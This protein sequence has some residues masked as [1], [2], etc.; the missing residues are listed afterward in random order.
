MSRTPKRRRAA[1]HIALLT[2]LL[3]ALVGKVERLGGWDETY[4]LTQLSSLVED[5][6]LDLRNDAL[7][8]TLPPTELRRLLASTLPSGA[9]ANTF[10]IGPA[11]M[12]APAYLAGLPARWASGETAAR[13]SRAQ[14]AALHLLALAFAFWTLWWLRS[15]LCRAGLAR[16]PA[17]LATAALAL[18]TPFLIYAFRHYAG[19]HLVSV[20]AACAFVAAVVR[21]ERRRDF[22]S[23]LACGILLGL[24]FLVRWQDLVMAAALLVPA[25][26]LLRASRAGAGVS[27]GRALALG[28]A[29]AAGFAVIAGLQFHAW[30]IERAQLFAMPQG[31]G[32]LNL[33]RPELVRFL[34][35]GLSGLLPWSPLVLLCL[36]GLLLPWRLRLPR[37]WAAVA[38]LVLAAEIYLNACVTDWWGGASY[39]ARRMTSTLPFLALGLANLARQ[40][41][42]KSAWASRVLPALLVVVCLWGTVTAQLY[43][44]GVQDLGPVFLGRPSAGTD[45]TQA[46]LLDPDSARRS[47]RFPLSLRVPNYLE[48]S[49]LLG[50]LLAL[51]AM[52]ALLA[53]ALTAASGRPRRRPERADSA[54]AG[55]GLAAAAL[56][57][58]ALATAFHLRLATGPPPDTVE[59]ASWRKFAG[60]AVGP[61]P[62]HTL[63]DREMRRLE[64]P[65]AAVFDTAGP[66]DA[67]RYLHLWSLWQR[68]RAGKAHTVL[69]TL[70]ARGYPAAAELIE[71]GQAAGPGGTIRF[72]LPGVL[73]GRADSE[74][75]L[76]LRG[77]RALFARRVV[78]TAEL[79]APPEASGPLAAIVAGPT[80]MVRLDL[81][82]GSSV[83]STPAVELTVPAGWSGQHDL[84]LTWDGLEERAL[85]EI[86]S[87]SRYGL[88]L[89]APGAAPASYSDDELAVAFAP[90]RTGGSAAGSGVVVANVFVA[91]APRRWPVPGESV[92][93][94]AVTGGAGMARD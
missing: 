26:R 28:G 17:L 31:P 58:L 56:A 87:R 52:A 32:Y 67:Y 8:A 30:G 9:L 51:A 43:R 57:V 34:F 54:P 46:G 50:R 92:P 27:V 16:G 6:D 53:L 36:I 62:D 78:V 90:Q 45:S 94:G 65:A 48:S 55:R 93:A 75:R 60:A 84:R 10:S 5:G 44:S 12:L 71:L 40:R 63:L 73:L 91:S 23:A 18:G 79:T 13:W 59:R 21:F 68:H 14:L 64:Q 83:L 80:T 49:P 24:V 29:V 3:A 77:E 89:T 66:V 33:A 74:L 38:L 35:S 88:P 11:L 85:L 37:V 7:W 22:A 25:R 69:T 42:A 72:A 47:L 20:V 82:G 61:T 2:L 70:A 39:G 76:R 1:L 41:P 4:Y 86:G 81:E 19:S 15:W